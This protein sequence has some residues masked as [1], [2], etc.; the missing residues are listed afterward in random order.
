MEPALAAGENQAANQAQLKG[1]YDYIVVG[2]GG[3]GSIIAGELSKTGAD[4]LLVESG[5]ADTGPTISNPSIWFYNVGGPL[6]WKLPIAPVRQLNNRKFNMALG[7]VLGGGSSINAMVWTRGMERDYDAWERGGAKGWGFKDVLP[8][9]KAQEDWEGGANEWRGV[10][11]PVH[12][13]KP[14]DPHPTAPAFLEAA[15][16]MGFPIID[17]V[18]G[19]MRRRGRLYQHEHCR[20]RLAVSA[21]RAFLRP[22]LGRPNLTLLLNTNVTKIL[23]D[24][25]RASG[26]EIVSGDEHEDMSG[27]SRSNPRRGHDPQRQ[28]PDAIGRR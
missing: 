20:G 23:F 16:Q 1:A 17:D 3:S 19:P 6:D 24:G 8:T 12:V 10:G 26:V 15:R 22:N 5:G 28:A 4:V 25:D 27:D 7:H 2:A 21:A 14:G 9:F 11:G 13:R 18:N